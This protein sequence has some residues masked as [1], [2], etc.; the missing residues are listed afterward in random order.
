[1]IVKRET[2]ERRERQV[3]LSEGIKKGRDALDGLGMG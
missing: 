2:D 3:Q 1:M